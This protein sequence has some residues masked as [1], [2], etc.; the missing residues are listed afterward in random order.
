ML[1]KL[2]PLSIKGPKALHNDENVKLSKELFIKSG[3]TQQWVKL[4]FNSDIYLYLC[5]GS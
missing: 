5:F 3:S 2:Y 4:V 1:S